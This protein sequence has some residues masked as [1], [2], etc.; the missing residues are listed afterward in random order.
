[1]SVVENASI[2][3]SG[4]GLGGQNVYE[5]TVGYGEMRRSLKISSH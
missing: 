2:R 1:M 5:N 3:P 4:D